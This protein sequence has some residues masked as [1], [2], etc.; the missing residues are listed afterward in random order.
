MPRLILLRH[1]KAESKSASGEDIDRALAER[2]HD[3][4]RLMGRVLAEA[5]L[6]PA[7]ALVSPA[8]RTRETWSDAALAFA[9][10]VEASFDKALYHAGSHAL[11]R[12]VEPYEGQ[13]GD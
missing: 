7:V 11:R 13:A 2:G 8:R 6:N 5:G 12:A 3:D 10:P 9:G 1:A 4:A